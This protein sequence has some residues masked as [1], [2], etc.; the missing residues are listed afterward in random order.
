MKPIREIVATPGRLPD[1]LLQVA[2]P[3]VLR[4]IVAH[5]PMVEAA[6]RDA[7]S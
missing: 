2:E 4:G 3:V 7:R 1:D 6:R 5:W